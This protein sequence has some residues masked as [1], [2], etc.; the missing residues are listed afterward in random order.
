MSVVRGST[1]FKGPQMLKV[2]I[3]EDDLMIADMTEE[4]LVASGY[5]VCGIAR[6]VDQA[7]ALAKL[8]PPDLA[9]IDL[10]LAAGGFGT[11]VASELQ[12]LKRTGILFAS[13][14]ISQFDLTSDDGDGSL[15]KPYLTKDLLCSLN[16]ISE[17]VATGSS[18]L[19]H[20]RGFKLLKPAAQD[21]K[22]LH[23][24]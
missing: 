3:V 20:P 23:A 7:V 1:A 6:T 21:R 15:V 18:A 19:P 8:N 14:N 16:I 10:R 11:E 4:F 2:L 5:A 13:G 24:R 12:K 22:A 17:I 9:I